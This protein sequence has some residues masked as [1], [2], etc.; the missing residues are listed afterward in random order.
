MTIRSRPVGHAEGT[1]TPTRWVRG[2]L[3]P[4]IWGRHAH[5]VVPQR[6]LQGTHKGSGSPG[7]Q[8]SCR[9]YSARGTEGHDGPGQSVRGHRRVR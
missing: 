8:G 6:A 4:G 1:G 7:I 9:V 2:S 5:E 3:P